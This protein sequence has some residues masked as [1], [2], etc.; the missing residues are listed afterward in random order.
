M[1]DNLKILITGQLN[2]GTTISQI[3][4]A[5]RGIEKK[6]NKIKINVEVSQQAT[7]AL[8]SLTQQVRNL[9]SPTNTRGVQTLSSQISNVG[10]AAS[11]A[12]H[13]TL[14]FGSALRQALAGI[15]LWSL[16]AQLVYAPVRALQDMTQRL[17]TI[18]T[19]MTDLRRVM[20]L[21]D[22]K[23]TE[24]LQN[25]VDTSD[26]LSSKLTDVLGIMGSFGRM[27]FN[28]NQL[29]DI[30]KTAQVLQNISD[31]DATSSVDTLTSA[32]LNFNISAED[33]ISIA[34][35]L[36]EVDNNFAITTKDLSDGI[37]KAAASAKTFGKSLPPN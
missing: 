10:N 2:I 11:Q 5:L 16:S 27:G 34:D 37:R 25:A 29:V 13:H 6:I 7:T 28:D 12:S 9:G 31:L 1:A 18:N 4:T 33:S 35:K 3:N 32:M 30:T 15:S 24:I 21:P 19:L 26:K 8:N 17:I 22:F 36:N 20:E 23:F 14:T